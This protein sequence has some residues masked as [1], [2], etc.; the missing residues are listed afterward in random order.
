MNILSPVA[1]AAAPVTRA[2]QTLAV[3]QQLLEHLERGQRVDAAILRAAMETAFGASDTSGAWDTGA[4]RTLRGDA[5]D[6][7]S[8]LP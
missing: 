2:S 3:A 1:L 5:A 8:R 6:D 7:Q 4:T